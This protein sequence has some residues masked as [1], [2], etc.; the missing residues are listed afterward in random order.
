MYGLW[1]R[2]KHL[3]RTLLPDPGLVL[4]APERLRA[5]EGGLG[6]VLGMVGIG[7]GAGML[8]R[9]LPLPI[10][11]LALMSFLSGATALGLAYGLWRSRHYHEHQGQQT[12]DHGSGTVYGELAEKG[13]RWL[14]GWAVLTQFVAGLS[15][16]SIALLSL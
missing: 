13:R 2:L 9:W 16:L 10:P 12:A 1:T 6:I 7:L 5:I 8:L 11:P 4:P 15:L 14:W 3:P